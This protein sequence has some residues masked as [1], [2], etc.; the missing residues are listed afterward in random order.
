VPG[1][2]DKPALERDLRRLCNAVDRV[3]ELVRARLPATDGPAIRDWNDRLLVAAFARAYRCLR[4]V[5]ELAGRGEFEDATV[6]TRTLVSITLQYLWLARVDDAEE[7]SDRLRRLQLKW[8]SERAVL[9]EELEDLNYLPVDG[10]AEQLREQVALFRAKA[11]ELERECVRRMPAERDIAKRLDRDLEP[12]AP[13]FFELVYA[14]IYR[15]A[16]HIAHYGIGAALTGAQDAGTDR[17]ALTLELTD[18]QRAAEALGLALVT[19]GALL[20]SS[21]PVIRHGLTDTV[22]EIVREHHS[23]PA[24]GPTI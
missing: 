11:N 13:R 24:R 12:E 17:G 23:L 7:R 10:T 20:D 4:S 15:P 22:A 1:E 18:E 8:A 19:F 21:E 16:S 6:L 5:R 14:R 2:P 3:L 9:G